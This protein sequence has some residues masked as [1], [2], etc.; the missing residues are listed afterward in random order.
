MPELPIVKM[1]LYKHGVAFYQRR[2]L[3]E[4]DAVSLVFGKED[5]NDVLKSLTAFTLGGGQVTGVDYETPEDKAELL[6]RSSIRLSDDASL[7][8]LLRDLRGR[9]VEVTAGTESFAGQVVGVDLPGERE[10]MA[11]AV[12][13][14]FLPGQKVVRPLL[15]SEIASIT[16]SDSRA[17]GDLA[18]VLET[19]LAAEDKRAVT[20]RLA[21]TGGSPATDL[22]VGYIAPSPTWRVSYRLVADQ[23]GEESR[24]IL[25]GWG[26]FDNTFDEDLENVRLTL[27]AGMPVSFVYDL[28]TPFTPERPVVEEEDRTVVAPVEFEQRIGAA[29]AG[30]PGGHLS[31]RAAPLMMAAGPAPQADYAMGAAE[32]GESTAVAAG[33]Q[34]QGEF[35]SY[36]VAAPVTVRRGRSAMVPILQ[37]PVSFHKARV[38]NAAKHPLNPLIAA[39]F[40]NDI[41]LTLER[42]PLTVIEDGEYAG[43]AMLPFT[44][45]GGDIYLAYAVDLGVKVTE[46][47]QGERALSS[48]NLQKGLLMIRE[49][50]IQRTAYRV[51]NNN[52]RAVDVT[53][54]HRRLPAYAPFDTPEPA[55]TTA[56]Y[57]RY[58]VHVAA[59]DVANF[60]A[61]HRRLLARREELRNQRLEQLRRWLAD[62]VLDQ[63]TFAVLQQVLARYDEIGEYESQVKQNEATRQAIYKQQKSIQGNLTSLRDQGEEG[64]LRTRYVRTLSQ[65]EDQ[66][67]DL[68]QKD[69]DLQAAIER[70]NA[71]I[72][73][74]LAAL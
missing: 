29:A 13:S 3:V 48:V 59:H 68:A 14:L 49:Y 1:T 62:R 52:D 64:Q 70:T 15:L 45:P 65:L 39:R 51:Q 22:V 5:M 73:A 10:P 54:E 23:A 42:G 58:V 63:A 21:P 25:Q 17:A 53:I 31:K 30:G 43:E 33:G 67:A 4:G 38:Y 56:G 32:L 50:D 19:S 12:L 47:T 6:E 26:L 66:L 28:Y 57:Y 46:E 34:R 40:K 7:R 35:F 61:Q 71:D 41:G 55:E 8:D 11:S 72:A 9:A 18:Y 36:V 16:L 44:G 60:T 2:G 24:G 37:S 27:V 69:K 74:I 20:V